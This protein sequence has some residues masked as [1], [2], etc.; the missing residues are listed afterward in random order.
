[1]VLA[2]RKVFQRAR[3]SFRC[4]ETNCKDRPC[5]KAAADRVS[6]GAAGSLSHANGTILRLAR[7][8]TLHVLERNQEMNECPKLE[9]SATPLTDRLWV[10][11]ASE[12]S[13]SEAYRTR[14]SAS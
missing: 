8:C 3:A 7:G 12:N 5:S 14:A 13:S 1:M 4:A 9:S 2:C 6:G 11:A 10:V